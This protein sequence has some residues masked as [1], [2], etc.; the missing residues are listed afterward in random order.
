MSIT[1]KQFL[2]PLGVASV[3]AASLCV[4]SVA[5]AQPGATPPG[6]TPPYSAPPPS[7]P[8]S[9]PGN[10]PYYGPNPNYGPQQPPLPPQPAKKTRQGWNIGLS[11]GVG[12]MSSS[13]GELECLD[14]DSE[15]PA[16]AFDLHAG[17]M[18]MPRMALQAEVWGMTRPLDAYGDASIGQNMFMLAVQYWLMDQRRAGLCLPLRDLQQRLRRCD[19]QRR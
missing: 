10:A 2:G 18:V 15:P 1:R 19:R 9:G 13:A 14:C 5:Q 16:F 17:T 8:P 4:A 12:S 6:S 3:A 11:L 7:A